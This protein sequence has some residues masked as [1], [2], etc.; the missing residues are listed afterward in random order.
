MKHKKGIIQDQKIDLKCICQ[1]GVTYQGIKDRFELPILGFCCFS[2]HTCQK[3][4]SAAWHILSIGMLTYDTSR[5]CKVYITD[6]IF[7]NKKS[8][9][10]ISISTNCVLK[11]PL[12]AFKT[13]Q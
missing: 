13:S 7:L 9:Y 12:K 5:A 11:L 1:E 8:I 10:Q 2:H 3:Q 4:E 6:F